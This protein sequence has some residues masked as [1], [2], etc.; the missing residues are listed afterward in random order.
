MSLFTLCH[1]W[2]VRCPDTV[3]N[4]DSNHLHCCRLGLE[5][6]ESDIVV[7]GS[8]NGYLSVYKPT[9]EINEDGIYVGY[10]PTDVIIEKQLEFPII[11]I[12]SGQIMQ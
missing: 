11:S 1:W 2:N 6:N 10:Q 8:F 12:S 7:V 3:N 4:Y 9:S 5:A